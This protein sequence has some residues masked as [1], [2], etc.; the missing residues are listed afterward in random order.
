MRLA[1]L[2]NAAVNEEYLS[3]RMNMDL[4]FFAIVIILAFLTV[5][6]LVLHFRL[7][8]WLRKHHPHQWAQLGSPNLVTNN[9]IKNF[10]ALRKFLRVRMYME[11]GDAE[12]Q[13]RSRALWIFSNAYFL[14]ASVLIIIALIL[15]LIS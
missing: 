7:I 12:L 9:S 14:I 1:L 5:S 3:M 11:L 8:S 10:F 13:I 15:L 4:L 6:G 2:L